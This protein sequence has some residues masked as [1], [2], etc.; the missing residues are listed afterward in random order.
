MHHPCGPGAYSIR[1]VRTSF[2]FV[3]HSP[4]IVPQARFAGLLDLSTLSS[5]TCLIVLE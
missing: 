3:D 1:D 4:C 5:Q 2:K